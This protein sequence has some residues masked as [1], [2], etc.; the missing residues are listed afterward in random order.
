MLIFVKHNR[1]ERGIILVLTLMVMSILLSVAL[2]F[3]MFIFSDINQAKMIDDSM[4]AYY[5][6]EAGFE[7]TIYLFRKQDKDKVGSFSYNPADPSSDSKSLSL[8][9]R[10]GVTPASSSSWTIKNSNDYESTVFRQY[11]RNGASVKLFF[12]NRINNQ[13]GPGPNGVK[14]ISIDWQ[15]MGACHLQ[16]AFTQLRPQDSEGTLVNYNYMADL[17]GVLTGPN[18][19]NLCEKFIDKKIDGTEWLTDYAVELKALGSGDD[20]C[21]D[22]MTVKA[23]TDEDCSNIT[24]TAITNVTIRS[25]GTHNKSSQE[26]V[27]HIP[28][29]DPALGFMGFVLFSEQDIT[30]NF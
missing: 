5:A 7:R 26:I 15:R 14:S 11:L 10:E 19:F 13:G 6:A 20:Y 4:L 18:T 25:I 27:A 17:D 3:A 8:A 12:L 9:D 1:D 23:Y 24:P 2:G 28:P 16:A 21:I 22:K 30:K 29:Y